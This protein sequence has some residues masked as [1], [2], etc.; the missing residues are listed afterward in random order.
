MAQDR[1]ERSLNSFTKL[2]VG[3]GIKVTLKK[4]TSEK[5][6]VEVR[7]IDLDDV[8]TEVRSGSLNIYLSGNR[9]YR[10][11]DVNIEVTYKSLNSINVSSAAYV[12][13]TGSIEGDYLYVNASSAGGAILEVNVK[14][15]EMEASSAGTV[16]IEGKSTSV[17]VNVSSAGSINAYDLE[18]SEV[19]ARASSAGS[20][21]VYATKMI[22]ARASSGGSIR[23]RGNP[24]KEYTNSSS[25]GSVRRTG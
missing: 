16:D 18:A 5:A 24:D 22:D 1:D 19:L 2:R 3:E 11:I 14:E 7:N 8:V 23:Y 20:A 25:G 12:R 15:I 6:V 17:E 4:G 10:N 21:K 9:H 13:T